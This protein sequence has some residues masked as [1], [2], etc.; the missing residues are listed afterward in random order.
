MKPMGFVLLCSFATTASPVRGHAQA[1]EFV[2]EY[3]KVFAQPE[4][5]TLA[6]AFTNIA[7]PPLPAWHAMVSNIPGDWVRS[8]QSL[9]RLE[10]LPAIA[11][12]LL[13][14]G[15]LYAVDQG[16]SHA[17][18]DLYSESREIRSASN[19]IK[20]IGDGRTTIGIA[21]A[22]AAYGL[23]A[24]DHR[25]F[26]TG[27]QA[28]E[29]MIASGIVVQLLKRMTGRESPQMATE[30]RGVWRPFPNWGEYN[31]QQPKYYAFPSGHITTT[32]ATVTV[33]AENYP[34]VRWI[35]PVGYT[36]VGLVGISL[37]NEGWHWYSDY[38]LGIALGYAFGMIA[39]H[40]DGAGPDPEDSYFPHGLTLM[41][42]VNAEGTGVTLAFHF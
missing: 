36:I 19:V 11:G 25:A 17:S 13:T 21:A 1:F 27:S 34:E 26:R 33:I 42:N 6:H 8:G 22:F 35:K 23:A 24:D 39:A 4:L 41:P 40:R 9:F 28:F 18:R 37:A 5:D 7:Q 12:I 3:E 16:A 31:S 38:P 10:S 2:S 20:H 15:I 30:S 29:A 32:M 14:T